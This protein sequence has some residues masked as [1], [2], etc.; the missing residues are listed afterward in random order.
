MLQPSWQERT[1]GSRSD[2]SDP[3]AKGR[4]NNLETTLCLTRGNTDAK[5][6]LSPA[7]IE[8][9]QLRGSVTITYWNGR[10]NFHLNDLSCIFP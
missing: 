8:A 1:C 2:P 5:P 6:F 9:T 4:R 10:L 3:S 7:A